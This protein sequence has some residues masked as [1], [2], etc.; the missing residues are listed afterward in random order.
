MRTR[1]FTED[2]LEGHLESLSFLESDARE[3]LALCDYGRISRYVDDLLRE[4]GIEG[5]EKDSGP[6]RKLCRGLLETHVRFLEI[7]QERTVGDYKSSRGGG[8]NQIN[9]GPD[10]EAGS[11]C[12]DPSRTGV[13]SSDPK[14]SD[15]LS[16]LIRLHATEQ[17]K[18]G[19][20]SEKSEQEIL[21]SLNL[22]VDIVGDAPIRTITSAVMRDLKHKL[23][24]LPPNHQK[25][26]RYRGKSVLEI[27]KMDI[28]K[29]MSVTTIN[30]HLDRASSLFKWSV[31][32]GYLDKNPA[33]GLQIA[34]K[35]RD[36]EYRAVFSVEDLKHLFL[37]ETY[38]MDKHRHGY[39]FWLPVVALFTGMRLDE[40]CQ[41]RL[42]DIY[43]V[44]PSVAQDATEVN[45]WQ[46]KSRLYVFDVNDKG[47]K[48][49]KNKSSRRL[50]PLHDFLVN[51]LNL[52]GY[53][54]RLK[55]QGH[56]RLFPELRKRRDGHGQMASKWFARYR[57]HCGIAGCE[58]GR[59][60]GEDKGKKDFHSFRH[61]ISNILKQSSVEPTVISELLGHSVGSITLSRY[62]KRYAPR[63]LKEQAV[64]R[65]DYGVNLSHLKQSR[66]IVK[67]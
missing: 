3:N 28:D 23:M 22:M 66:F 15:R 29:T 8:A 25:S 18:A 9:R 61:T 10:H 26:P 4:N 65:L 43:Q 67:N 47:D 53:V 31:R 14:S 12:I 57:T 2:E 56:E 20:W 62:G 13:L 52:P 16:M 51:D 54:E 6:Y 24:A 40:I 41:L 27:L 49:L 30:K 60:T 48:K 50:V 45:G 34:A 1:P 42:E 17:R 19:A 11:S 7:E 38:E 63:V 21:T 59:P 44:E 55:S 58:V 64:D 5:I 37:S 46:D 32:N 39:C 35:K 33:D 36:D